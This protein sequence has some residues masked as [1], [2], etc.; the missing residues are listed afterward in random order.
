MKV[1]TFFPQKGIH[2]WTT[3]LKFLKLN[4]KVV[5]LYQTVIRLC[6]S[7]EAPRSS[8]VTILSAEA[9]LTTRGLPTA[10]Q[11]PGQRGY[12]QSPGI[13]QNQLSAQKQAP[14]SDSGLFPGPRSPETTGQ[15]S[16]PGSPHLPMVRTGSRK[17][18]TRNGMTYHDGKEGIVEGHVWNRKRGRPG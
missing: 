3:K 18:D 2:V 6:D 1:E 17:L 11:S 4:M 13:F 16:P 12:L 9:V 15:P 5:S 14:L 10:P 7:R 8:F